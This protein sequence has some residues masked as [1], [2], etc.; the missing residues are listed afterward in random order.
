[1]N[2]YAHKWAF[3]EFIYNPSSVV[4]P[5]TSGLI[6]NINHQFDFFHIVLYISSKVNCSVINIPSRKLLIQEIT[7]GGAN[8]H[9]KYI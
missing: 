2:E 3:K 5:P 7:L 8:N 6:V 4:R 9:P 1:M